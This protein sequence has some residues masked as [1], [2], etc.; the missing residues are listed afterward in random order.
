MFT[1][2][3]STV[4]TRVSAVA[5]VP[6]DASRRRFMGSIALGA[7]LLSARSALALIPDDDDEELVEKAKAN[8]AKRLA[9][10]KEAQRRYVDTAGLRDRSS[11]KTIVPVQNAVYKLA[12][13]GEELEKDDGAAAAATLGE[14]WLSEFESAGTSLA[15][16]PETQGK[17][18]SIVSGIKASASAASSG[19]LPTAKVAYVTA[20]G[21]I[22]TW[23]IDT[24][25]A[26]QLKGL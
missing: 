6:A 13:A 22:E 2:F 4:R 18:S 24:G 20:V 1:P 3:R 19:D 16:T 21:E 15:S 8:R 9:E 17:L 26:G 10:D 25:I 7:P 23:V 14:S 11:E 12:K 5:A